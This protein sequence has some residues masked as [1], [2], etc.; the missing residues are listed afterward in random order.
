MGIADFLPPDPRVTGQMAQPQMP[1]VQP[2]TQQIQ[3]P[4]NPQMQALK[5]LVASSK[6]KEEAMSKYNMLMAEKAMQMG[7]NDQANQL[8]KMAKMYGGH[9]DQPF[10]PRT[11]EKTVNG[12]KHYFSMDPKTGLFTVDQGEIP[13][14]S[15]KAKN[16][17]GRGGVS[18]RPLYQDSLTGKILYADTPEGQIETASPEDTRIMRPVTARGLEAQQVS[19][20]AGLKN[21]YDRLSDVA[22]KAE[23]MQDKF[24]PLSGRFNAIKTKF[25]EEGPTQRVLNELRS[26]ITIAYGLSGKQISEQ[27]MKMLQEAMLPTMNQPYANFQATLNFAKDWVA[28]THDDRLNYFDQNYFDVN[29]PRLTKK[30]EEPKQSTGGK[31][32]DPLGLR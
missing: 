5:Q 4:E 24:G 3:Q 20:L 29:T 26:M 25:M 15:F 1:P 14:E 32:D 9:S 31:V 2:M 19:E 18:K 27:E 7:L 30:K 13:T 8:I 17:M 16:V 11:I 23:K 6:T 28:K 12:K 21:T 22:V 10:S